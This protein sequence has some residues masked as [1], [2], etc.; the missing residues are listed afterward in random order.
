MQ[1]RMA[2]HLREESPDLGLA[3]VS[4]GTYSVR[5]TVPPLWLSAGLYSLYFKALIWGKAGDARQLSDKIPL[6][7]TGLHSKVDSM[8][9]PGASWNVSRVG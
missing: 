3:E 4:Q 6:D 9:H 7:I 2:F 1:N 8:L 5:V